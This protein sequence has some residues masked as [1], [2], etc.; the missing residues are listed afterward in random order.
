MSNAFLRR[1]PKEITF[2][3]DGT[4]V[5]PG[6]MFDHAYSGLGKLVG[7]N[8]APQRGRHK[9]EDQSDDAAELKEEWQRQVPPEGMV[10]KVTF[11]DRSKQAYTVAARTNF[12]TTIRKLPSIMYLVDDD[13]GSFVIL[14][15]ARRYDQSP[16]VVEATKGLRNKF[17][18]NATNQFYDDTSDKVKPAKT[19]CA[20]YIPEPNLIAAMEQLYSDMSF[21]R[22]T[23]PVNAVD[24]SS[25][26]LWIVRDFL[27]L[28][29]DYTFTAEKW[30]EHLGRLHSLGL[31]DFPDR[32]LVHYCMMEGQNWGN[33][34]P[35]FALH[36]ASQPMIQH[37]ELTDIAQV[38]ASEAGK[39][40]I[41]EAV[42]PFIKKVKKA[43][44]ATREQL[45][46]TGITSATI[47]NFLKAKP[48][49]ESLD[50]IALGD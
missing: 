41:A 30:G 16:T 13:S 20:M 8:V 38:Y 19:K 24:V 39:Y 31:M 45:Q 15:E 1:Q 40:N 21:P 9:Y 46:S 22:I 3:I 12:S 5:K 44:R 32:Q 2:E 6:D 10:A 47:F 43:I 35:D 29:L 37:R 14:R 11:D 26:K 28:A 7:L 18:W 49:V 42:K 23:L 25:D 33:Y 34:D 48:S 27:P 4:I 36:T 17:D 50:V